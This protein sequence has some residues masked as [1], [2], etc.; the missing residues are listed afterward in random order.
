MAAKRGR[1]KVS[2]ANPTGK[3]TGEKARQLRALG[4]KNPEIKGMT[5]RIK[6][7]YLKY[8][9]KP[10]GGL[11]N[12]RKPGPATR[13]KDEFADRKLMLKLKR[14]NEP[15]TIN[16][17]KNK[18]YIPVKDKDKDFK[19]LRQ[20]EAASKEGGK[21]LRPSERKYLER[22]HTWNTQ[23]G[24][25]DQIEKEAEA[26]LFGAPRR[27]AKG[28]L[29]RWKQEMAKKEEGQKITEEQSQQFKERL[30]GQYTGAKEGMG[31]ALARAR[32]IEKRRVRMTPGG[33]TTMKKFGIDTEEVPMFGKEFRESREGI[34]K[35][36]EPVKFEKA[37][38]GK[39][40]WWQRKKKPKEEYVESEHDK[41]MRANY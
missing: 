37:E 8:D 3:S 34:D 30:T 36:K 24:R 7:S 22:L 33:E 39:K 27:Y 31:G 5:P 14:F 29:S 28:G 6:R 1:P 35:K 32:K 9:I 2:K 16:E 19:R 38:P 25:T 18:Y 21:E 10:K 13:N 23:D 40:R 26:G 20:K 17:E 41:F 15:A 12:R 4:W 11:R